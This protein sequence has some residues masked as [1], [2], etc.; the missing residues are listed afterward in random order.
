MSSIY[1]AHILIVILDTFSCVNIAQCRLV[2]YNTFFSEL[3]VIQIKIESITGSSYIYTHARKHVIDDRWLM[4]TDLFVTRGQHCVYICPWCPVN[5]AT[6][7]LCVSTATS[8]HLLL[9]KQCYV[10]N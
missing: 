8:V 10:T 4:V 7:Q 2:Q 5:K 6:S 3:P 1:V 9:A